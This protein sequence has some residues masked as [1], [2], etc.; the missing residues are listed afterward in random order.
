[1]L[2]DPVAGL[3]LVADGLG[4]SKAGEVASQMAVSLLGLALQPLTAELNEI[5]ATTTEAILE[6]TLARLDKRLEEEIQAANKTIYQAAQT[7]H[8]Q[9]GMATTLVAALFGQQHLISAH[10]G[11]S[12]LYRL[13]DDCLESLTR[14]HSMSQM[15]TDIGFEAEGVGHRSSM[16]LRAL[17]AT[18]FVDIETALHTLE[19]GDLYLLCTDGLT[20]MLSEE[21]IFA[22]LTDNQSAIS[23]GSSRQQERDD[24][25]FISR[26]L[27]SLANAAGGRDNISIVL[28]SVTEAR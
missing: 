28:V 2:V 6:A 5:K 22:V 17:G 7:Q 8:A 12:R 4:G 13:R 15:L 24:L 18:P 9:E 21:I 1:M 23:T 26:N 19:A 10:V 11:D 27:V 14:D 16:L 20:N 3:A 25:G